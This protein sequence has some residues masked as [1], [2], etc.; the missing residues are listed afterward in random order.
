MPKVKKEEKKTILEIILDENPGAI[1]TNFDAKEI[2][3]KTGVRRFKFSM[4]EKLFK[5]HRYYDIL[6]NFKS[7]IYEDKVSEYLRQEGN[8][9]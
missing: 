6:L 7:W 8:A 3:L 1:K 9:K 4:N 5:S 2:S